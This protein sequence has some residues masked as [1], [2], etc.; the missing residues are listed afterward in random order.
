MDSTEFTA[1]RDRQ[2]GMQV[3]AGSWFGSQVGSTCWLIAA[4][5]FVQGNGKLIGGLVAAFVGA[6]LIGSILFTLRKQ[7]PGIVLFELLIATIAMASLA[8]IV[9]LDV[10]GQLARVNPGGNRAS[11][12]MALLVLPGLALQFYFLDRAIRKRSSEHDAQQDSQ[13][14][15]A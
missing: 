14:G 8:G 1:T 15:D 7:W 4:A 12:Y 5:F 6:N 13:Q 11:A 3:N 10:N 9:L 2:P